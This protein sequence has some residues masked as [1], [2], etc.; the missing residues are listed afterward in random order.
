MQKDDPFRVVELVC[1]C[2]HELIIA[3]KLRFQ[4]FQLLLSFVAIFVIPS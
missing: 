4:H 3:K 2:P 1:K